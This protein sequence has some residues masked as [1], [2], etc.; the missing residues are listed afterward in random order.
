MEKLIYALWRPEDCAAEAFNAALL[1]SVAATLRPL[2]R[3][4]RLN[5]RDADVAGGTSPCFSVMAPSPDAVAQLWVDTAFAP[6]IVGIDAALAAVSRRVQSWLVSESTPMPNTRHPAEPGARTAGFSQ[7]AI[8]LANPAMT[9]EDWRA[10]W[11]NLHTEPAIDLQSTF[12]Y[13]QN[14]VVRPVLPGPA[15]VWSIVEECFPPAALTDRTVYF[16]C[17]GDAAATDANEAAMLR[18]VARFIGENQCEVFPT[19]QYDMF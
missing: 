4:L 12:E 14:L 11:Q 19:S 7:I 3:H 2:A 9:H 13:V 5:L 18:S 17:S 15:A 10:T 16:N 8:L 1:R 6:R